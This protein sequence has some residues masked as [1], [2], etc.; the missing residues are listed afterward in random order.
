MPIITS[1]LEEFKSIEELH[2]FAEE[3]NISV[4]GK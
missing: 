2:F 3:Q 1:Y 4:G